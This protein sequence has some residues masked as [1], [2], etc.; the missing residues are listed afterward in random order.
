LSR[1]ATKPE[2]PCLNGER[3]QK[4]K[5]CRL[6]VWRWGK[7]RT[8]KRLGGIKGGMKGKRMGAWDSGYK[9]WKI[10]GANGLQSAWEGGW[11]RRTT[12][13]AD[14]G[15]LSDG[16]SREIFKLKEFFNAGKK[17]CV[18]RYMSST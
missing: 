1:K 17:G 18:V 5:N 3:N 11:C 4:G 10:G 15:F 8:Q 16:A 6:V 2:G 7:E 13:N 14:E 9:A 12:K